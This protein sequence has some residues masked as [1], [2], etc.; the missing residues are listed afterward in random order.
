M[1]AVLFYV[2]LGTRA[3]VAEVCAEFLIG[4]SLMGGGRGTKILSTLG[5]LREHMRRRRLASRRA[6][7]PSP[8]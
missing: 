1:L 3:A 7:R 5:L 4:L 8:A 6:A 2:W